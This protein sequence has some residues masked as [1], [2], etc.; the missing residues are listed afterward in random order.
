[1]TGNTLAHYQVL[2]KLGQG[3]MGEVWRAADTK[4]G[5]DVAIEEPDSEAM[6]VV[7]NWYAGLKQ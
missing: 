2:E 4:L 6:T 3:G 1:M 7:L 5:R